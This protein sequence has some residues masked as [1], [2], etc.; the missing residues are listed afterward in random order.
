MKHAKK[1]KKLTK[2]KKVLIIIIAILSAL[3]ITVGA[4][5]GLPYL[6]NQDVSSTVSQVSEVSIPEPEPEPQ[7][8]M[9]PLTGIADLPPET[10]NN[11]PIGIVVPESPDYITQLNIEKADMY[12]EAET[13]A[14]IPRMLAV[15]SN[16]D[17]MPERVGPV[18]SA[19]PHFVRMAKAFD[20]VYC[21]IG[22]SPSG[23]RAIANLGV[24]DLENCSV[25]D[26][27]LSNAPNNF[28]WDNKA[29]TQKKVKAAMKSRGYKF[30]TT[31]TPPFTFGEK[32]GTTPATVLDIQIS[33]SY[34]M[35]FTY[36]ESTKMYQKHRNSLNTKVHVTGTGGTVEV[37]NVLVMYAPR[38]A[39]TY[40]PNKDGKNRID[41]TMNSGSGVLANNGYARN[42]KWKFTNNKLAYYESDGV[43]PLEFAPGK[44]FIVLTA[45]HNQS[46]TKISGPTTTTT[47]AAT[48][49]T[50]A[51]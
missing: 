33:D 15:F 38:F 26:S 9:N 42:I 41:F 24:N 40:N 51:K 46:R 37:T 25:V 11:R 6:L 43:T 19:R 12:F 23:R 2:G 18:R 28:S 36:V 34:D 22:G 50:T 27:T 1:K 32:T 35:A 14:G 17:R 30:T 4:I 8:V 31:T 45:T 47:T 7:P 3:A 20:M 44:T 10:V 48:T 39:D 29:F 5:Y 13:E 49:T 16:I 21:H